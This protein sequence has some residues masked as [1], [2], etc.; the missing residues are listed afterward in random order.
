[1]K[2]GG[3]GACFKICQHPWELL[4]AGRRLDT[5]VFPSRQISRAAQVPAYVA[6]GA[7]VLK[8]QGR[9][10]PPER[11]AALVRHYRRQLDGRASGAT[12]DEPAALPAS[13]TVVGR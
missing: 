6:A 9:S 12:A 11:L 7:D 10:L 1:M 3:V 2:R 4:D 5:R 8:L 13:W